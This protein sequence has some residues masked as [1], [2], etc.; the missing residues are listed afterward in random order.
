MLHSSK[1][2]ITDEVNFSARTR[3]PGYKKFKKNNPHVFQGNGQ[4]K[5]Y[6][7]GW[8]FKMVSPDLSSIM[9]V[10][11][12]ISISADGKEQHAFIQII[13]GKT[14]KTHYYSFPIEEFH[15]SSSSFAIR[16]GENYFSE[17]SLTL[18]IQKDDTVI[19]GE[20]FMSDQTYFNERRRKTI[21]GWT[22]YVPFMQC[23]HSV[24]SLN[25]TLKGE[26]T[27]QE[28]TYN[29]SGGM[30][31]IEKNWGK[32]MPSSWIWMQS[33]N[34]ESSNSSF[35]FAV[36]KVRWMR[37][38]FN[39]FLGYYLHDGT[40]YPFATHTIAKLDL[41]AITSDTLS[42]VIREKSFTLQ[43][44]ALQ[45]KSGELLAPID[46]AMERLI[47]ESVN[48]QLRI[49]LF[50]KNGKVLANDYTTVAGLEIVGNVE[51]LRKKKR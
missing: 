41:K 51:K 28:A 21:M 19:S 42:I 18:N 26:I 23:Y 47:S 10:I 8:Y 11:P 29:F 7:E 35:M 39:G 20:V 25:H 49:T 43:I 6:F 16:I 13:D 38:S 9:S 33:N 40:V 44:E 15:F 45:G 32:S 37:S 31:Y 30:G 5:K 24:V 4:K 14:A 17:D 12:G 34:F 27:T 22:R 2:E 3:L 36:A 48:G 46:G 1:Q 50:D